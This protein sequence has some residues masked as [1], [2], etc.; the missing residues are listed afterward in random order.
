M[1]PRRRL[2]TLLPAPATIVELFIFLNVSFLSADVYVAHSM[3]GFAHWAEWIPFGYS[4]AAPVLLIVAMALSRSVQPPFAP[5]SGTLLKRQRAGRMLGMAIGSA[6]IAV[7]VMGLVW[8]LNS[9]FFADATLKNLVFTAPFV[10]PLAYTGLGL[11]MVLNRMVPCESAE[12]G[13]WVV[14]LAWGGW[15]GNFVLS[16]ADHAQNAF[17]NWVEWV[18]V[19]AS[20]LAIGTLLMAAAEYRNRPFLRLAM[21]LMAVEIVV[22]LVGW[23]FHLRAIALSPM[24]NWWE[25]IVF[26][27][28]VFA[29]LLFA[30]LAILA[31]IGLVTLSRGADCVD[32]GDSG[33]QSSDVGLA[34]SPVR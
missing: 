1:E 32:V 13:R 5:P 29:P 7:G 4:V 33:A 14:L 6:A 19:V 16:L 17:F 25:R 30:N 27:A 8:H 20:A 28:P 10:A 26:S 11:L 22:A 12:W 2:S 9:Q 23:G 3:N 31:L 15:I 21:G 18:P 34:T 24:N